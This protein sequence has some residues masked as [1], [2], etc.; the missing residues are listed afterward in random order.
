MAVTI[1]GSRLNVPFPPFVEAFIM[2]FTIEMIREAGLRLPKPIGQTIGLIG[3]VVIGQAAVQANIVSAMMVIVV[4]VTALASFT[5]PSYA[6]NFPLRLIRIFSMILSAILGLYGL[7]IVLSACHR[8]S[9]AS[10]KLR[11]GLSYSDHGAAWPGLKGYDRQTADASFE[12]TAD[13][14]R[15]ER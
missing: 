2:I 1:A 13:Q 8:P 15:D 4:S 10:E 11:S 3:G 12:K 6:F 7:I 9:D 14:K 5:A